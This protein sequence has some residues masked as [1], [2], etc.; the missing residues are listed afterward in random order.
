MTEIGFRNRDDDPSPACKR[1]KTEK[2]IADTGVDQIEEKDI[3]A[4]GAGR[5]K[6]RRDRAGRWQ[7]RG[8]LQITDKSR[9]L[10][11][12]EPGAGRGRR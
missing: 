5:S 2:Q 6:P 12:D 4:W 9:R 11:G 8:S 1:A 7:H 3:A 10:L